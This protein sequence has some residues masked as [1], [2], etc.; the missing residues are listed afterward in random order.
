VFGFD[1]DGELYVASSEGPGDAMWLIEAAK[2]FLLNG[3][4]E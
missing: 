2:Q 1:K 4:R 3:P